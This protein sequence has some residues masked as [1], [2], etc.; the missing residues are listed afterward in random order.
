MAHLFSDS[1]DR[2]AAIADARVGGWSAF[3]GMSILAAGSTA[4]GIGQAVAFGASNNT[5][6]SWEAATNE[7]TIYFSLRF[8]AS[9]STSGQFM[10]LTLFDAASA[11]VAIRWSDDGAIKVYTGAAGTTLIGTASSAFSG[12]TW[13]SYQG[14]VVINNTTGSVEIRKN[15]SVTP[16]LNLTNV[17]TRGGTTNAYVNNFQMADASSTHWIDDVWF[18]SDN[19]AAPTSWP[20]DVRLFWSPVASQTSVQFSIN[21]TS[22]TAGNLATTIS[23][24]RS[25]NTVYV[26][27]FTANASGTVA[28]GVLNLNAGFTGNLKVAIYAA[29]GTNP[30]GGPGTILATSNAVVNPGAG[31][32]TLTFASPPTLVNGV[33]YHVARL[34]DAAFTENQPNVTIAGDTFAQSYGSGFPTNPVWTVVGGSTVNNVAFTLTITPP[35]W[36][37]VSDTLQDGDTSYVYSSTVSQKDIYGIGGLGTI[38]PA[39]II[40]VKPVVMWK[41]SDS[42]ARTGTIGVDAN[43]SGDTAEISGVTPSLSYGYSTKFMPADP[44]SAGWTTANVNSI[45]LSASVAS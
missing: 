23:H 39:S 36:F 41:K 32:N 1:F 14:K 25:A 37:L 45:K 31:N 6:A 10:N 28:S 20:G 3:T 40:G 13:D 2:Y 21:P 12:L 11:Q 17:N 33:A 8:R 24:A 35:N 5:T 19:G 44:T 16:L 30:V 43:S 22:Y 34:T 42:G 9:G 15:G 29:D 4:F 18:N 26:T 27:P 7:T 38:N